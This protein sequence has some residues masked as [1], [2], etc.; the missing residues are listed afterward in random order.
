MDIF[1]RLTWP[2]SLG[3]GIIAFSHFGSSLTSVKLN[4]SSP[5]CYSPYDSVISQASFLCP[6]TT[7]P[8]IQCLVALNGCPNPYD[9]RDWQYRPKIIIISLSFSL[10]QA[11]TD[12]ISV[13]TL[14]YYGYFKNKKITKEVRLTMW[15]YI[16]FHSQVFHCV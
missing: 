8:Q 2:V 11:C 10:S 16:W 4:W 6:N 3:E 7:F 14:A 5:K 9:L 13:Y 15:L 1:Y 12:L